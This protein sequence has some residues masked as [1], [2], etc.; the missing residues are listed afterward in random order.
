MEVIF[1]KEPNYRRAVM[2]LAHQWIPHCGKSI[3]LRYAWH[4]YHKWRREKEDRELKQRQEYF[5]TF[6]ERRAVKRWKM[7]RESAG[8]LPAVAIERQAPELPIMGR[9]VAGIPYDCF[10]QRSP[11]KLVSA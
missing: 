9:K 7:M 11:A 4:T 3:A 2:R 6:R 1:D 8:R 5:R 10:P